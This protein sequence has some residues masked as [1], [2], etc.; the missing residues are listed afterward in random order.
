MGSGTP[1][2]FFRAY[3]LIVNFDVN[4][5]ALEADDGF[6]CFAFMPEIDFVN[7]LA[8]VAFPLDFGNLSTWVGFQDNGADL[9][10]AQ[11]FSRSEYQTQ[12]DQ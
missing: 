9:I 5:L 1:L 12:T 8:L 4:N 3:P 10:P 7:S 2:H 6:Q 11:S